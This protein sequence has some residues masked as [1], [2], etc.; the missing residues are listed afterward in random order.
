VTVHSLTLGGSKQTWD[1]LLAEDYEAIRAAVTADIAAATLVPADSIVI[2]SMRAGSLVV[3]FFVKVNASHRITSDVVNSVLLSAPSFRSASQVYVA[4]GGDTEGMGGA[5]AITATSAETA[6]VGTVSSALCGDTCII[7][8]VAVGGAVLVALWA[9]LAR[10]FL[11]R[12]DADSRRE[13]S[14]PKTSGRN[15]A[16]L[17]TPDSAVVEVRPPGTASHSGQLPADGYLV[18]DAEGGLYLVTSE[19][20]SGE[21]ERR[22]PFSSAYGNAQSG[23]ATPSKSRFSL[24]EPSR[25][26]WGPPT[27]SRRRPSPQW[28][29]QADDQ[30][31]LASPFASGPSPQ[32]IRS[33]FD[34]DAQRP[35]SPVAESITV[36]GE[37]PGAGAS[38]ARDRS[39]S[40]VSRLEPP[41]LG[42]SPP[43]RLLSSAADDF[44]APD[45]PTAP[46]SSRVDPISAATAAWLASTPLPA[47]EPSE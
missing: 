29:V 5:F 31:A 2:T 41:Q 33:P 7:V 32:R 24:R 1:R 46:R 22:E 4:G 14:R 16:S 47:E 18:A 23:L 38:A 36:T 25:S 35:R 12:C 39:S 27:S 40:S 34:Y 9:V 42:S 28:L 21:K 26:E 11:R 30:R 13:E 43:H 20:F 37:A 6:S 45:Y 8:I 10:L 19:P 15:D 17:R 44:G 3:G